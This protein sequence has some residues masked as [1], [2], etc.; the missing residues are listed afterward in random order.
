M[1]SVDALIEFFCMS[2]LISGIGSWI[3][4]VFK[5]FHGEYFFAGGLFAAGYGGVILWLFLGLVWERAK[6][7][8]MTERGSHE[9]RNHREG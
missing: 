5:V 4:A 9:N 6:H 8:L 3:A 1:K 7:P 2:C